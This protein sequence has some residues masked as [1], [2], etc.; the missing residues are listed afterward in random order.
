MT[1]AF[2][3]DRAVKAGLLAKIDR[4][5]A[6]G[7]IRFGLT[8]GDGTGGGTP[9]AIG[10]G[11]TDPDAYVLAYGYPPALAALLDPLATMIG[12]RDC[13]IAFV[14]DWVALVEP[15]IDLSGVPSAIVLDLLDAPETRGLAPELVAPLTVLHRREHAGETVARAEWARCRETI[16]A[17]SDLPQPARMRGLLDLC[18]A[19]CWSARSS[20]SILVTMAAR[21]CDLAEFIAD[22]AWSDD[23]RDKAKSMFRGLWEHHCSDGRTANIPALFNAQAPDLARR[24][25]ANLERVNA[26]RINRVKQLAAIILTHLGAQAGAGNAMIESSDRFA[27]G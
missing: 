8:A 26:H 5:I 4:S 9:V 14:R 7:T 2:G 3:G 22:P 25:E 15:G 11:G 19:A 20:R 18:E 12:D 6:A 17:A 23:D 1:R 24:F 16:L 21:W 27:G 10:T 13:A